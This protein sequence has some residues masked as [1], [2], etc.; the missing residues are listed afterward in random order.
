MFTKVSHDTFKAFLK[1]KKSFVGGRMDKMVKVPIC[2]AK[3]EESK[4]LVPSRCET[5][6]RYNST[7]RLRIGG[8]ITKFDGNSVAGCMVARIGKH[9]CR[10]QTRTDEKGYH[11]DRAGERRA[12]IQCV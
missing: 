4:L 9:C 2:Y 8:R 1:P 10:A 11:S 7:G 5:I 3:I 6:S 12:P